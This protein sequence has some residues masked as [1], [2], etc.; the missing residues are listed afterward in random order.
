MKQSFQR[1]YMTLTSYVSCFWK[2]ALNADKYT[3]TISQDVE[4]PRGL[5]IKVLKPILLP[6]FFTPILIPMPVRVFLNHGL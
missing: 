6:I 4:M 1:A 2:F 3:L 5:H